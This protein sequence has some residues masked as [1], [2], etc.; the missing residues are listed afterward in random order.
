MRYCV[1]PDVLRILNEQ[2]RLEKTDSPGVGRLYRRTHRVSQT[3]VRVLG[4]DR[5]AQPP[6]LGAASHALK[7]YHYSPKAGNVF[8]WILAVVKEVRESEDG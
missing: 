6:S 7:A 5:G 1:S 8:D 4:A 3:R 2:R